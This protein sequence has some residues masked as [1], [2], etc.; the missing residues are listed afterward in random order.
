MLGM[1]LAA[2]AAQGAGP[3]AL[4]RGRDSF[5]EICAT[6]HGA[7]GRGA[8]GRQN[9]QIDM[10]DFTDCAFASREPDTDWLAVA[11]EGGPS[12]G[13]SPLMP[14]HGESL[15]GETLELVIAH[16]RRFCADR[17]WP[18]GELNLPRP[19]LTEKAYP[20]D[21]LVIEGAASLEQDRAATTELVYEKRFGPRAQLELGLPLALQEDASGSRLAGLGDVALG[22]KYA[23]WHDLER[24]GIVSLAS[25]VVVPTGER[26]R[27][28][29][30]GTVVLEP[31]LLWGQLL[32]G[33]GFLQ[34]QLLGEFPL[35]EDRGDPEA[36]LRVALGR[37]FFE[38][39][40]GR[41]WAPML[42]LIG[43]RVFARG[44]R[45]F[46]WDAVPQ[47]Q[48]ALNRRQHVRLSLGVRLPLDDA[49]E[50]PTRALLY[51]LWDWYDG[52]LTDGW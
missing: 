36:Q 21:E 43:T 16:V 42:E 29:G 10:P 27:G 5:E 39:R 38:G 11:H 3:T 33:D 15:G 30:G 50:R 25:E 17:R 22:A 52:G 7:D 8:P 34:A 37:S 45:D 47:L 2:V 48:V 6:C 51:L 32:P 46:E 40:F 12:R 41:E 23:L 19:Q 49:G 44:S 31:S 26:R 4:D 20:E 1:V 18:R 13:F 24:G 28:L 14:A 9:L 35:N